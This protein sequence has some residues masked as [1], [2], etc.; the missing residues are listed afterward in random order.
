MDHDSQARLRSLG[1][2]ILS[3][4]VKLGLLSTG[5]AFCI[6]T[7]TSARGCLRA[8]SYYCG[9]CICISFFFYSLPGQTRKKAA[10][11]RLTQI[12]PHT[13]QQPADI[14]TM[15]YLCAFGEKLTARKSANLA[16]TDPCAV[17]KIRQQLSDWIPSLL[18]ILSSIRPPSGLQHA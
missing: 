15:A 7:E 11:S 14:P 8:T 12:D 5:A 17:S 9:Y 13:R 4:V 18:T 6:T 16:T 10:L 3:V 1:M 2:C